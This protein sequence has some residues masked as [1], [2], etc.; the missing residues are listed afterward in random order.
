MVI[1]DYHNIEYVKED[2]SVVKEIV[3]ESSSSDIEEVF[4]ETPVNPTKRKRASL[5]DSPYSCSD[6]ETAE[7][8]N[9]QD[10]NPA[11]EG[12]VEPQPTAEVIP[13]ED[14]AAKRVKM[15][16]PRAYSSPSSFCR[17]Y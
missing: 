10:P 14:P 4:V 12:V 5:D 16:N 17:V 15:T 13:T 3:I 7:S 9:K 1:C 11:E 8:H 2:S 6:Q